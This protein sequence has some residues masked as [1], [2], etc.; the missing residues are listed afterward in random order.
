MTALL[1]VSGL[2]AGYGDLSVVHDVT[3]AVGAGELVGIVG[4][5]GAGKSTLL[6]A[7]AGAVRSATGSVR[8]AGTELRSRRAEDIV[9]AG[10]ALV[11]EGRHI[12]TDLT[13]DENLRL[14]LTARRDTAGAR[15]AMHAVT[16]LFPVLVSHRHQPAGGLSGGQQQQ[17]AIARALVAEPRILLLDEPSLGLAPT[18]VRDV[19]ELLDGIV[20]RGTGTVVVEQRAHL[21]IRRAARTHILREGRLRDTLTAADDAD[22]ARLEAAYFGTE[23]RSW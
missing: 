7:V 11:P 22:T 14:G 17:L 21:L 20:A 16:D 3:F 15:T 13:V 19:F 5:N 8:L 9:R 23:V 12:F 6:G 2:S 18:V 10:L 1:D 4:P